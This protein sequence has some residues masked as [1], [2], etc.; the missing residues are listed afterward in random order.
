MQSCMNAF[1][2]VDLNCVVSLYEADL[3]IILTFAHIDV[4]TCV[5]VFII[6]DYGEKK[7]NQFF[8]VYNI[9]KSSKKLC[10]YRGKSSNRCYLTWKQSQP[11]SQ[12]QPLSC[13]V[14][15]VHNLGF[16][17]ALAVSCFHNLRQRSQ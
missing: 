6:E 7:I 4:Y 10:T 9:H 15:Y 13:T 11:S 1:M 2:L 12:G 3:L 17:N 8:P 16:G 5:F 14:D